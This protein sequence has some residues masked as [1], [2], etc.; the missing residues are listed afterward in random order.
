MSTQEQA[1]EK[2]EGPAA[3]SPD[4]SPQKAVIDPATGQTIAWV[5]ELGPEAAA[6][7]AARGRAVQPA[8]EALGFEGRARIM[9]RAQKWVTDHADE[10]IATI[11]SETGKAWEDAQ[12]AEVMYAA[13]AFGH[14][15][16]HAEELLADQRIK[17]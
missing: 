6:K 13:S 14:W 2:S 16:D 15:A 3:A 17:V 4:G 8:W 1:P 10:L 9:R 12:A 5:D 7:A 11:V